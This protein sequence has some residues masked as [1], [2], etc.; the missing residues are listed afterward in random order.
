MY[1]LSSV[2]TGGQCMF[3]TLAGLEL[4][5]IYPTV[6]VSCEEQRPGKKSAD[7]KT[8]ERPFFRLKDTY[9]PD[10]FIYGVI[11]IVFLSHPFSASRRLVKPYLKMKIPATELKSALLKELKSSSLLLVKLRSN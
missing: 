3:C 4:C 7:S 5:I 10:A 8:N 6:T 11:I 9:S 2:I 1:T